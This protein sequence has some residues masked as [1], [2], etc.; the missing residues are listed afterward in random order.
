[1]YAIVARMLRSRTLLG[2]KTGQ[3][4]SET[5]LPKS[6]F[7]SASAD[8]GFFLPPNWNTADGHLDIVTT[9]RTALHQVNAADEPT[10]QQIRGRLAESPLHRLLDT[11]TGNY[12]VKAALCDLISALACQTGG[13]SHQL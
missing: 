11:P 7:M 13:F 6:G 12:S 4:Y 10:K 1:M 9:L 5:P 8:R 3:Q 2:N